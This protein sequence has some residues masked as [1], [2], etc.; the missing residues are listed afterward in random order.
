MLKAVFENEIFKNISWQWFSVLITASS[1]FIQ[2]IFI[3]RSIGVYEFGLFALAMGVASLAMQLLDIRYLDVLVKHLS[4]FRE[5][6]TE[7][8][9]LSLIFLSFVYAAIAYIIVLLLLLLFGDAI[10]GILFSEEKYS[11]IK[12]LLI[13][14]LSNVFINVH[15]Y[16]I[17]QSVFRVYSRVK[18]LSILTACLYTARLCMVVVM[19]W[20]LGL[21]LV[22]ALIALLCVNILFLFFYGAIAIRVLLSDTDTRFSYKSSLLV[23][24]NQHL[25]KFI[26]NIYFTSLFSIPSKELDIN[27]LGIMADPAQIGVYRIAKN[28]YAV[29]WAFIDPVVLVLYADLT[30]KYI[31]KEYKEIVFL[32]RNVSIAG[33]IT[34]VLMILLALVGFEYII[35]FTV[36]D[37]FQDAKNL[38]C[39][40]LGGSIIW[41]SFIW[42]YPVLLFL[43]ETQII[44]KTTLISGISSACL[45]YLLTLQY[46]VLG[47]TVAYS[48]TPVIVSILQIIG[49][50]NCS[51]FKPIRQC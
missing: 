19:L 10:Q 20:Y 8:I 5:G 29:I 38:F 41:A 45:F 35:S 27:I 28:F 37:D 25:R 33:F 36:G 44:F 31:A 15:L 40:M 7:N 24:K 12:T 51:S 46:G 14:C 48:L 13:L 16:P 4:E 2:S 26:K 9:C 21:G 6:K 23:L 18:A 50:R 47:T 3:A 32:I 1:G 39:V 17:F 42:I 34:S 43:G 49:L 11:T 22:S 30:K